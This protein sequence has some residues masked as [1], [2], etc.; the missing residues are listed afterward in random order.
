MYPVPDDDLELL[1]SYLDDALSDE[2]TAT[3]RGRLAAEPELM[4][5]LR[6]LRDERAQRQAFFQSIDPSPREVETLLGDIRAAAHRKKWWQDHRKLTQWGSAVAACLVFALAGGFFYNSI[7]K[8]AL[9]PGDLS[10]PPVVNGSGSANMLTPAKYAVEVTDPDSGRVMAVQHF[11]D[12][13]EADDFTRD[14]RQMQ[15][16]HRQTNGPGPDSDF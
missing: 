16:R 3:L 5:A 1:E 6:M 9:R 14:L 13:N 12:K 11:D 4:A 2:A 7:G 8:P 15:M 10:V